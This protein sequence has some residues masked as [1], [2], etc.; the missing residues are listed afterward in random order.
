MQ[1]DN[2]AK[3]GTMALWC[4]KADSALE[5]GRKLEAP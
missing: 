1:V 5:A 2:A 4:A 3:S